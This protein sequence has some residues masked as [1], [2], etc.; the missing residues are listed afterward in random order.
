M[1]KY[2][3]LIAVLMMAI[4]MR[5]TTMYTSSSLMQTANPGLTF[6]PV[7]FDPQGQNTYTPTLDLGGGLT[8]TGANAL[9]IPTTTMNPDILWPTGQVLEGFT[10]GGEIDITL[11]TGSLAFGASFGE[12]GST[13]LTITLSGSADT[14]FSYQ[15]SPSSGA[16][17]YIGV[18]S[19]SAFTSIKIA[20][21]FPSFEQLA[22]N[23]FSLGTAADSE[24]PEPATMALMGLGL[25]ML[26]AIRRRVRY[27]G[28]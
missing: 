5:A 21:D 12:V 20:T 7:S 8:F 11:P 24:T 1:S 2:K 19:T 22:L 27:R 14:S 18:S 23:N 10:K 9:R 17:V 3:F 16:P 28:E 25:V 4:P 26:A 13:V 15:V 6:T